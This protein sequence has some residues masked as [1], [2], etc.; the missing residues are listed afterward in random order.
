MTFTS[1]QQLQA[2]GAKPLR[3]IPNRVGFKFYGV[4][5]DGAKVECFVWIPDGSVTHKV[6]FEHPCDYSYSDLVG[7]CDR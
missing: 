7:W 5:R 2:M 4:L 1:D 6:G 3:D